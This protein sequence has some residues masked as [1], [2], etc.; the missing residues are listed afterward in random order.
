VSVTITSRTRLRP[1]Q[2]MLAAQIDL[3]SDFML[4]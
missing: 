1:W 4:C 2:P 3:M